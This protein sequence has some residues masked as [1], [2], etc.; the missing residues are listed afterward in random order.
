MSCVGYPQMQIEMVRQIERTTPTHIDTV[1]LHLAGARIGRPT[2]GRRWWV[3]LGQGRMV[4]SSA[5]GCL[6]RAAALAAA[7]CA[8]RPPPERTTLTHIDAVVLSRGS[9][10]REANAK[11]A[12]VGRA[13][14]GRAVVSGAWGRTTCIRRNRLHGT[15]TAAHARTASCVLLPP[16]ARIAAAGRHRLLH[17]PRLR[18]AAREECG[19]NIEFQHFHNIV[20]TF[21]NGSSTSTGT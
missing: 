9:E 6:G 16:A 20:S 10:N 12:M 7:S 21:Q 18:P 8:P 4:M 15:T 14:Q 5:E 13:G 3:E 2:Q 1:V 17:A 11:L 19:K